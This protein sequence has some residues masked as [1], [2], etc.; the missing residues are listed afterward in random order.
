[1]SIGYGG[2]AHLV[3]ADHNLVI[4]S[5]CCYNVNLPDYKRFMEIEDG[6]QKNQSEKCQR[7]VANC[8]FRR[9]YNG[10]QNFIQTV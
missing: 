8:R 7:N 1:M 3:G 5:Y 6:E 9:G 2:Y 10:A 4:Y